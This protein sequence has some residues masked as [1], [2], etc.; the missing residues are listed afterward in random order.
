[1]TQQITV[2][3]F[4]RSWPVA[5]KFTISRGS[6]TEAVVVEVHVSHGGF[7][8][9]GECVPYARYNETVD[10]VIADILTAGKEL[11]AP[12]REAL[13]KLLPAGAARNGLDCALWDLE[14]KMRGTSAASLLAI[15][16]LG[17]VPTAY[18]L[19]LDTPEAMKDKAALN[20]DRPVLKVKLGGEGDLERLRA[21]HEGAPRARLIID[22][23]EAWSVQ[24]YRDMVPR[25]SD[26]GVALIEQPFP[27]GDDSV[28]ADLARPI[29]VC[30]D[31]SC[32]DRTDLPRLKGLYDAINIKLD[33]AGGL[34]EG[35]ALLHEA[36]A[37]GFQ[38][39]TGCMLST[40]LSMAPAMLLA[41]QADFVDLDGPLLLA[42]DHRPG[43]EYEG[44]L[45][46]PPVAA[47]WG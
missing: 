2:E 39:M 35:A 4:S 40:S 42:D 15:S 32:H 18:T 17:P 36:K 5:G 31:E 24:E 11:E 33:K 21:V 38:V 14:A 43:I 19:S 28:L 22:A 25:L 34:T 29:T 20:A 6:R 12:D 8:G 37:M 16:G 3:A 7:T 13:Q 44:S 27:A 1:M 23:N 47:L 46:Y 26:L 9:R 41:Q 10:E 30:A 45:A